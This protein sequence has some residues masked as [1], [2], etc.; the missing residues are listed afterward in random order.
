MLTLDALARMARRMPS[1]HAGE[2][3]YR[4]PDDGLRTRSVILPTPREE[5]RRAL[6]LFL[7]AVGLSAA[8]LTPTGVLVTHGA[9]LLAGSAPD[10]TRLLRTA[11]WFLAA[12]LAFVVPFAAIGLWR[13][14]RRFRRVRRA[15]GERALIDARGVLRSEDGTRSWPL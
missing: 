9:D 15:I 10:P 8:V 14:L 12:T 7:L 5:R 4:R 2:G 11:G 1:E 3:R 13:E 6:G